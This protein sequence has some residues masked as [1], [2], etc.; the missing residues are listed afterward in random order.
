MVAA[1]VVSWPGSCAVLMGLLAAWGYRLVA[2]WARRQ[3]L[4]ATYKYAPG[5][6][7]VVQEHGPGGPAMWIWVGEGQRPLPSGVQAVVHAR[8]GRQGSP[9]GG[10]A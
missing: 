2:E 7:V 4:I 8:D 1:Q 10:H 5:G 3:T 6:T 9:P